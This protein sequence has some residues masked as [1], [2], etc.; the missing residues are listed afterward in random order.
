MKLT[1]ECDIVAEVV[2][3]AAPPAACG[4]GGLL[5]QVHWC[6]PWM[7]LEANPAFKEVARLAVAKGCELLVEHGARRTAAGGGSQRD[8]NRMV[9]R[10]PQ[11]RGAEPRRSYRA[12]GAS[13][14]LSWLH[15][16]LTS[17]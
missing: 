12:R 11:G 16:Y 14:G 13:Q 15:A 7:W 1:S 5:G 2:V 17:R 6:G 4:V 9:S 10:R 3:S 8:S